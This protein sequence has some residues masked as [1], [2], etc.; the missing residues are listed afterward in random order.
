M[1]NVEKKYRMEIKG[2]E[3]G[4][5]KREKNR[6]EYKGQSIYAELEITKV[7]DIFQYLLKI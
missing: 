4:K 5:K 3:R 1:D 2:I 6:R 7:S